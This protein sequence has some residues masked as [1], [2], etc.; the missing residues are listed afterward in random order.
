MLQGLRTVCDVVV[1]TGALL[2]TTKV[3]FKA[4]EFGYD[5]KSVE[6]ATGID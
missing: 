5:T 1:A 4:L 3:A 2:W 6:I